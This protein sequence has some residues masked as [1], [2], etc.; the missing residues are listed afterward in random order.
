MLLCMY[1]YTASELA[2][3]RGEKGPIIGM[4]SDVLP[5][6]TAQLVT[7]LNQN[8]STRKVKVG[9]LRSMWSRRN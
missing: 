9:N 7:F 3:F 2:H 1:I 4:A 8:N 6:I 5:S